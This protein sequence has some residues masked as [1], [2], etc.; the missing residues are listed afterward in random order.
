VAILESN[1][2]NIKRASN[3]LNSGKLVAF[4]TETVYGLG[5]DGFNKT[6]VAKIFEAKKR[7]SFNPLILHVSSLEM[8]NEVASYSSEKIKL[9]TDKFWP[10]PLTLILKKKEVVPYIVTSGLE[11]VAVRMPKNKIALDLINSLGRPIAAPSANNFSKLSPTKAEHV[12]KQLGE[13]VEIILDGGK[14][15]VGVE[16]TIIEVT[17]SSQTL[18]R[19]GG[20]A[21]EDIEKIIGKLSKP[22]NIDESPNSP[23]QLHIHYAPIIPI[24]FYDKKEIA[25]FS[26]LKLGGVFFSEIKDPDK[27]MVA[28]VLSSDKSLVEAA[29]N[30]FAYL[31][32][33]E[34]FDLDMIFIEPVEKKGLGIAIMDRLTKAVNKYL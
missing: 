4:P 19:P 22:E 17:N 30:L 2:E 11:T 33:M 9:L 6:A 31:H 12:F 24:Y 26:N 10:G 3:K 13:K 1:N 18:L 8:L 5:A 28:K 29:S 20:V 21:T 14:C 15:D 32:E 23:G 25:K 16:S 27:F 7:P 34:S